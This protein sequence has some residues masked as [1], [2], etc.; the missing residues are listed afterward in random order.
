MTDNDTCVA[1]CNDGSECNAY[2]LQGEDKCRMHIG[3]R[4]DSHAGNDNAK[5][6][7]AFSD[8]FRGDLTDDEE[9]ALEAMVDHLDSIDDERTIAAE[10]AAEALMKY[11]RSADSRFLREARQ[12]V[13]DF[14]L[15]PNED[16]I[17]M[18]GDGAGIVIDMNSSDE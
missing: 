18:G 17:E 4:G 7:G 3:K 15:L 2:P 14:N 16:E 5:T 8:H 9:R 1:T 12:W 6:H 13:A 11:K 10:V